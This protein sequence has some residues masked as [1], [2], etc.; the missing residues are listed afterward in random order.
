M[1]FTFLLIAAALT[2]GTALLLVIPLLRGPRDSGGADREKRLAVYRQQAAELEEDREYH[3]LTSEQ[4]ERS[5][6]ELERRV[7][8]EVMEPARADGAILSRNFGKRLALTL[9]LMLP[10]TA[11][12]LYWALGNPLALTHPTVQVSETGSAEYGHRSSDGLEA[13]TE[14]LKRKLEQTPGDGA[15]WALLARSY[16][17]L[18]R[19]ADAVPAFEHA[20]RAASDDPQLLVDYADALGMV[21][22]RK[23][24]G[25]PEE[26]VRRALALDPRNVKG[27]LLAGTI[28]YDRK[29]FKSALKHWEDARRELPADTEPEVAR[30]LASNIDEVREILG[31]G[32]TTSPAAKPIPAARRM[33][34]ASISGTVTLSPSL[35][36]RLSSYT[37]LFVFAR[38][39]DGPPVP[40]AIVRAAADHVPF[41]FRL[42]DSNSPMPTRKLSEVGPVVIVARLSK[43]GEAMPQRGDL[44]GKS[45]PVSPGVQ[46]VQVVIDTEL[47]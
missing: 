13:L 20:L 8:E 5:R 31:L 37:S 24:D 11:F 12:S 30:E 6:Q 47:P 14:R 38:S 19:H 32:Q 44:Q 46:D 10:P 1:T 40:V 42:D 33:A 15:G 27:M 36:A 7:M 26:L 43:S 41:A 35:A 25:K 16:V 29:D 22:G 39:V 9:I 2:V 18:D 28:A 21:H 34:S 45:R 17:E 4:F 3:L 23:L